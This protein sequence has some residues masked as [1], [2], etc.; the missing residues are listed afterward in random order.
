MISYKQKADT[1]ESIFSSL[2]PI[3]HDWFKNKF[4]TFIE[5]QKLAVLDINSRKNILVSASTGSGKTLTAFLAILNHLVDSSEKGI[6]EDKIYAVYVSPLKALNRDISVNLIEPL[7]EMEKQANK[8][9][10]IR[11]GVRTGDTTPAEKQKMLKHVPHILITTPESLAIVLSSIKFKENLKAVDWFIVDEIHALAENKRGTHLS[12][13][14]ERLQRL[15]PAMCRIGLSATVAP[16][17]SIAQFLVG[18]DRDCEIADVPAQKKLD[19][20]VLSP[21]AN[22]VNTDYNTVSNE[23]YKLIDQLIQQHKTTLIFT[24]TRSGTER[25]V[26]HLKDKF[27]KN[28]SENIGAH[29]GSLSKKHRTDLEA[30]LRNGELK[31]VV[32]STSLELGIDIGFID[33]VILLGSPKSV[34]RALQRIGR[35]GHRLHETTKGRIIVLDRDDLVE[36]SVLLKSAIERK[37]DRIHIPE[38]CLDVLAQQIFGIALEEA[39]HVDDLFK[40]IKGSYCYRTLQREDFDQIIAYLAGEYS[41]LQDR[42]IYARIWYDPKTKMLGKRG[43][44]ARVIYMTNVGTIPEQSGV[45]VK[46][47]DI[48]VGTI[49]EA[50]LEKLKPNDVFLLGGNTYVFRNA[51]GMVARVQPALGRRPTV[52]SWYSEML[53]LSFDLAQEIGRFRKLMEEQFTKK[54]SKEEI[55]K[56]LHDFL[57]VDENAANAVYQYFSE[58]YNYAVLPTASKILVEHYAEGDK[59]YAVFHTLYGRRVNDCLSRAVAYAISK[60]QHR[61]VELGITDNGFYIASVHPIQ[62]VKAFELLKA[63]RMEELMSLALEK[64]E[65][66]RRRFRH[67][68][69]RAMM[70]L[71]KYKGKSK[72]AGRQQVSSMIL[73]QAVKRISNEFPILKEARREV[74]EDLMDIQNAKLVLGWIHDKKIKLQEITTVLPSPFSFQLVLQGYFDVMRI[75]DRMEFLRRMHEQIIGAIEAKKTG[76]LKAE[77]FDYKQV[78]EDIEAKHKLEQSTKEAKLKASVWELKHVPVFAKEEIITMIDDVEYEPREDFISGIKKYQADIEREW[79]AQLRNFVFVR[80]GIRPSKK[81]SAE[82]DL[83]NEQLTKVARMLKLDSEIVYELR[84]LIDGE[85]KG[86]HESFRKWLKELLKGSIPKAWPDELIKFLIQAE[87]DI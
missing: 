71:G 84:K 51:S 83:L 68:A 11:V 24:N 69:A 53:P 43:K 60:I 26:H 36:C 74:L 76:I 40:L 86:F 73:M 48:A 23:T 25:V 41:E 19:L 13:S 44:M 63:S 32:C 29:H 66:L 65:V 82:E 54:Q 7:E 12:I 39:I 9:F 33:L 78:W 57:Y 61:D 58:Q 5:P 14:M 28:Y 45:T 27:P 46:V 31:V 1:D 85:R 30:K 55:M 42:H 38:N 67:C 79:P 20:K 72:G 21:V 3:V 59:K 70:I 81:F 47:G 50:F 52:P 16:L 75:E 56:F 87:K 15:S 35:A 49:D 18:T 2:N 17:D 77:K 80:I 6:L 10:G 8:K 64:T 37:I 22:L 4:K 34:A 62:A